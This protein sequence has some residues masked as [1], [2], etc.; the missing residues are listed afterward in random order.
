[1]IVGMARVECDVVP[2]HYI[3]LLP[4]PNHPINQSHLFPR[5][6]IPHLLCPNTS[7]P[8]PSTFHVPPIIFKTPNNTSSSRHTW[9]K[10]KKIAPRPLAFY[11][12]HYVTGPIVN[13]ALFALAVRRAAPYRRVGH[14]AVT[15]KKGGALSLANVRSCSSITCSRRKPRELWSSGCFFL[16]SR[17]KSVL[18]ARRGY[19]VLRGDMFFSCDGN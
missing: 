18:F 13:V 17:L 16:S 10:K 5:K 1:M 19:R 12:M 11:A 2:A 8:P 4:A 7:N 14:G 6:A 3:Y 9:T 15:K